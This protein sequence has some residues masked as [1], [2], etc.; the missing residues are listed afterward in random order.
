MAR[1]VKNPPANA[2]DRRDAGSIPGSG[3]SPGGGH[4]NSFQYSCLENPHGHGSL[5][6][7]SPW[8]LK[9]SNT[10]EQLTLSL[11][12]PTL[13][14]PF[15]KSAWCWKFSRPL[16]MWLALG[17]PHCWFK[18]PATLVNSYLSAFQ[19]PNSYCC[20]FLSYSSS[21]LGFLLLNLFTVTL[22]KFG[23]KTK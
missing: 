11:S 10:T 1:V 8:G 20:C 15:A 16:D 23:E 12:L 5:A 6:G 2:G 14:I 22:V 9:K 7:C 19:L 13:L 18:L 17:L 4:G 21:P 3:R